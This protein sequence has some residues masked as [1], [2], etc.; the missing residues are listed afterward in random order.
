MINVYTADISKENW[1]DELS[2]F[3]GEFDY[4]VSGKNGEEYVLYEALQNG[5]ETTIEWWIST[6][7]E[8]YPDNICDVIDYVLGELENTYSGQT[9]YMVHE[10]DR[11][12]CYIV[13]FAFL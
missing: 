11:H 6:G 7:L 10:S 9:G 12:N 13:S 2:N 4:D 1:K 8:R 5:F 3:I